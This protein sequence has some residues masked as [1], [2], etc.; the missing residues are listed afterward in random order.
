MW[1]SVLKEVC[2]R[3]IVLK[4]VGECV[5]RVLWIMHG[6][7]A[8]QCHAKP[9][10]RVVSRRGLAQRSGTLPSTGWVSRGY[11]GWMSRGHTGWE[12]RGHTDWR[13]RGH[14]GTPK[15]EPAR[16]RAECC[17]GRRAHELRVA[18]AHGHV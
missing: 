14:T 12:S 11:T 17:T 13:L 4:E 16:G 3:A 7:R 9:A 1:A 2:V 18:K 5:V 8:C 10:K 6:G 15:N